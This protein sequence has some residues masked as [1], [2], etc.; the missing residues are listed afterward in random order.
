MSGFP[1]GELGI[2]QG[3]DA[4]AI[5]RAYATRLKAMDLDA[6]PDAYARLRQ[7]RDVA[8]RQAKRTVAPS[9]PEPEPEAAVPGPWSLAGGAYVCR[10]AGDLH[11]ALATQAGPCRAFAP[12]FAACGM[13]PVGGHVVWPFFTPVLA[14]G[15]ASVRPVQRLDRRLHALLLGMGDDPL[16]EEVEDEA[17]A[18]LRLILA[19][20]TAG[21]LARREAIEAWLADVLAR[22]WPRCAPL[23]E[24][25][26]VAMGWQQQA[27]R[28]GEAPQV[29]F[30]TARLGGYLFQRDVQSPS[31]PHHAAWQ[32]L[33]REGEAGLLR[34]LTFR[35]ARVAALLRD[36]RKS[37][38]ELESTLDAR[39]IHSWESR[40]Q[41][42]WGINWY[43]LAA[44]GVFRLLVALWHPDAERPAAPSRDFLPAAQSPQDEAQMA[45]VVKTTF[46]EGH[47]SEWL[48][49]HQLDLAETLAY[50]IGLKAKDPD[51]L[52]RNEDMAEKL[53]RVRSYFAAKQ[54]GG[55][56]LDQ[57]MRQR[58]AV[59][60]A[61]KQDPQACGL[62]MREGTLPGG[63]TLSPAARQAA[64]R[65]YA[66]Q[67][68]AGR[69]LA[70][71]NSGTHKALVPGVL[72]S[73]VFA[74]TH[75]DNARLTAAMQ[76][77]G[78]D[79]DRCGVARALL[80]ATLGWQGKEHQA[81]LMTL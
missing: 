68:E 60:D 76:G 54:A 42:T 65:L 40:R 48:K 39:R 13:P 57:A 43:M 12:G 59:L 72:V 51:T 71:Q 55:A 24:E 16:G 33:N 46:G 74:E 53:V 23:L 37:W 61:L 56:E 36:I 38:P 41:R 62:F 67:A 7:A 58:L 26:A 70:P 73:K 28:L 34:R 44:I 11:V 8:L 32:E 47:S 30:L 14:G 29:A 49:L 2:A 81:I 10:G 3:G 5:R 66:R 79:A 78:P 77:K 6:D 9:E 18:C 45:L 17:R 27:G 52:P 25:A 69:L 63:F 50:K 15:D 1:W 19:E 31:H 22:S 75:M 20:A 35:P 64:Q 21:S 80:R 4:G